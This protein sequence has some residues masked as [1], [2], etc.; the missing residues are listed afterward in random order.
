V[1]EMEDFKVKVPMGRQVDEKVQ[2]AN[3]VSAPGH[4]HADAVAGGKHAI[5]RGA[6]DNARKQFRQLF[7]PI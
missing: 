3:G 4:G 6:F 5:T 2:E 1:I 7:S